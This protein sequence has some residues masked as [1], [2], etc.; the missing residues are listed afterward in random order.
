[1]SE[2]GSLFLILI[3]LYLSDC[4]VWVGRRTLL[5]TSTWCNDW[6]INYS[7]DI[8][9]NT[10]GSLTILNPCPPLGTALTG[11]WLPVSLSPIGVC[12]LILQVVG[13]TSRP[14]QTGQSLRYEQISNVGTDGKYLLL[15]RAR[16]AKCETT[17]QAE[18]LSEII[19]ILRHESA[20]NR[21]N[22]LR[23]FID[24]R[25][26]KPDALIRLNEVIAR[27]SGIRRSAVMLFAFIYII[28][29]ISVISYGITP[30]IIPIAVVMILAAS[31]VA[32][33]YY[34]A[35]KRLYPTQM[36][37]RLGSVFKMILCP[38]SAI[39]AGD[40]LTI[41]AMTCFHPVLI[42][43]ILLDSH[44]EKFFEPILRDL[45]NPLLHQHTD[46]ESLTIVSWHATSE[47]TAIDKLLK[48]NN[49]SML[50]Y[51]VAP[52]QQDSASTTYC[53]RCICQFTVPAGECPDCPGVSLIPFQQQT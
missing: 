46:P 12:D 15:N 50:D 14:T 40:L 20:D 11:R 35:H 51:C 34:Y 39:R 30:L 47:I 26:S 28:V 44:R 38:P 24:S 19:D 21:E 13:K 10:N 42:G 27:L 41:D 45:Q 1:M 43:D 32:L 49:K 23:Q 8:S 33:Q 25:F 4:L 36:N 3:F 22:I 17:D 29:P 2:G 18:Y 6:R 5:L 7:N 37:K 9:G 48:M 52:Q 53:P 31:A 16:F